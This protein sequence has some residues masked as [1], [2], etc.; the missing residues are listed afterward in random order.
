MLPSW[1]VTVLPAGI[2]SNESVGVASLA[3]IS[4]VGLASSSFTVTLSDVSPAANASLAACV[5]STSVG[6]TPVT[7]SRVS[8]VL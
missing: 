5:P 2:D 8:V 7:A 6:I 1:I 4:I 3:A